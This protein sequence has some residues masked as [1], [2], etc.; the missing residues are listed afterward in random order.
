MTFQT[1][2]Y[3]LKLFFSVGIKF[4]SGILRFMYHDCSGGLVWLH[5]TIQTYLD[6]LNQGIYNTWYPYVVI[7]KR[8][9]FKKYKIQLV[10]SL[11]TKLIF[12]VELSDLPCFFIFHGFLQMPTIN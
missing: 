7:F 9:R 11:V 4:F 10:G 6:I 5:L 3:F 12:L 1:M 2:K 8:M